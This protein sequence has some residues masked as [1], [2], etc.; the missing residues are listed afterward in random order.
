MTMA[1][2]TRGLEGADWRHR[3]AC[4]AEDPE[5]FFPV[6]DTER[7]DEFGRRCTPAGVQ[8]EKALAVC[9]RCP[10]PVDC[11]AWARGVGPGQLGV[12]GGTT[13]QERNSARR[14]EWRAV[15]ARQPSSMYVPV[16]PTRR[17]VLD[18]IEAGWRYFE[19]AA[20]WGV[21]SESVESAHRRQTQRMVRRSTAEVAAAWWA[22]TGAGGPQR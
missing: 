21:S 11:F 19:M 22:S 13:E 3:G 12:V 9:A 5:L 4:R 7:R 10:V 1:E 18:A 14:R 8:A 17:I 2:T 15:K 16:A 6:G 20:A